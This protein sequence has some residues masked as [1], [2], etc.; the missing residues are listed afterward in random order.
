[1]TMAAYSGPQESPLLPDPDIA[2]AFFT[3][4][5]S[6][7]SAGRIEL[8]WMDPA[9]AGL[10]NFRRFGLDETLEAAQLASEAS[11]TPGQS[12][13]VR[14]CTVSTPDGS[15]SYTSDTNFVQAPGIWGD[16]DTPEQVERART[17][18]TLVRPNAFVITGREPHLRTQTFFKTTAPIVDGILVRSLNRRLLA[19]YGGDPAVIN[20]SRLMR[21]PGT[22]AWPWK[23]G[24]VPELTA[25]INRSD[26]RPSYSIELL[27]AQLPQ[28]PGPDASAQYEY[29]DRASLDTARELM[30]RIRAGDQWHNNM[31]RLVAHWIGRGWSNAE[32]LAAAESFTLA[33]YTY[34]QT[35][36]EVLKAIE[37]GRRRWAK[38]DFEFVVEPDAAADTPPFFDPWDALTAPEFPI[39]ALP[40]RLHA[41]VE[42]RSRVMGLDQAGL[43]WAA[44]SACSAAMNGLARLRMKR[45]DNWLVPPAIWTALVGPS[46]SKKSPAI[47]S[48]WAPL[49]RVQGRSLKA[50]AEQKAR[51]EALPKRERDQTPEPPQPIR[52]VTHGGT[53]E[54]IQA[55]LSRQDRGLG[56]LH[57]ELAGL[58]EGMDRYAGGKGSGER[59]FYLRAYNGGEYVLDR[60]GRGTSA[61]SNLLLTICGGIQPDKLTSMRGL[62][63]DGFWQRF[64]PIIMGAGEVGEDVPPGQAENDYAALVEG[65]TTG[66]GRL[67]V[68]LSDPAHAVR[69]R[70]ERECFEMER[71]EMLGGRFASFCGKLPGLWGRL[72]LVL[73][74]M[75]GL[76]FCVSER[77]ANSAR[78]LVMKSAFVNAGRIA[79]AQGE[80]GAE[81]TQAVAGYILAKKKVR[82][83]TSDLT[84]NVW[85]CRKQSLSQIHI[86]LS[87][88]VA[89]GWLTP[90]REGA[91][92]IAWQVHPVVHEHF[93]GRARREE[94]RRQAVRHHILGESDE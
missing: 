44:I 87:P 92:N 79:L 13:Y 20:P 81:V 40:D 16:L 10:T 90:E 65:L 86:M 2:W 3:W 26:E 77:V 41:F 1:M 60:V 11:A 31:V 74:Q 43:A 8:G 45:N 28:E 64:V 57:D 89:G 6:G 56:V 48:A 63:D 80:G 23:P 38:P 34:A 15:Q 93:A 76:P 67:L 18:E 68:Q 70:V 37:G 25:F 35:H 61:S 78:V 51:W 50:W 69:E 19:L 47:S 33:G 62:S 32:I 49:E 94:N 82:L 52:F 39:H 24:R 91:S 55:I 46:S 7:C 85:V 36:A 66:S 9:G 83:L 27:T 58:I 71:S 14:A 29:G 5:F 30:R 84:S 73:S 88:L 72:C 22:I 17:I 59:A 75:E 21:L 12:V 54:S 53:M 42:N 4:W